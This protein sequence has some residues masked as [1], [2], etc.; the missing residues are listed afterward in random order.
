MANVRLLRQQVT[1]YK[2]NFDLSRQRYLDEHEKYA[3]D[4]DVFNA[5]YSQFPAY[6]G[7]AAIPSTLYY[8]RE[9]DSIK[10]IYGRDASRIIGGG[11]GAF[12]SGILGRDLA[13]ANKTYNYATPGT[14]HMDAAQV[15][16]SGD[17]WVSID[18]P[19]GQAAVAVAKDAY[20]VG[21]QN[22]S[23]GTQDTYSPYPEFSPGSTAYWD[24]YSNTWRNYRAAPAVPEQRRVRAPNLTQ[25]EVG[26]L[27]GKISEDSYADLAKEDISPTSAFADPEDP[28]NL[29]DAGVLT[30]A[31]AGKI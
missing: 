15:I 26:I 7:S 11:I 16:Q 20:D 4:S 23:G 24:K 25:K 18:S 31:I 12:T 22:Y 5:H 28:Y 19:E 9:T 1:D 13:P 17:K 14:A 29:K 27:E 10:D 2:R 8:D 30:R 6:E 3:A 21:A